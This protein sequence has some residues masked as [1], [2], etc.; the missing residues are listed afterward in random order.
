MKTYALLVIDVQQAMTEGEHPHIIQTVQKINDLIRFAK[1]KEIPTYYVRH[2][3][4]GS[5]FD[6]NAPTS[7][8]SEHLLYFGNDVIL[9]HYKNAFKKTNLHALLQAQKIDTVIVVGFQTEYCIS[10]TIKGAKELGYD[11]LIPK[12][13]QNTFDRPNM[14]KEKILAKYF[15]TYPDYGQLLTCDELIN[16]LS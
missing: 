3:E 14:T 10:S 12:E 8:L 13:C 4:E 11:V 9:K 2:I 5:E 1:T 15:K 16:Q 6:L 7:R